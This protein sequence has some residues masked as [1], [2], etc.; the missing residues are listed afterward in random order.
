MDTSSIARSQRREPSGRCQTDPVQDDRHRADTRSAY[1][2]L[3]PVW[4]ETDDNLFNEYLERATVRALLPLMAPGSRVLYA[5]CAGGAHA[6]WLAERGCAVVGFDLSPSMMARTGTRCGDQAHF[7]V[8]DLVA[9]PFLGASFDGILCSLAL[10][11]VADMSTT[12]GEF[13]R[14][15]R[16]DGWL[17]VTLDHPFGT[18]AGDSYFTTRLATEDWAKKGVTV[19][20]SFWRRPLG[21][22]IDAFADAGFGVERIG[23]PQ[24]DDAMRARFPEDAAKVEGRPTFIAYLARRSGAA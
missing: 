16:P 6:A 14:I 1:E 20:Q 21:E 2:R 18:P 23:E 9:P 19:T 11:Y 8:A 12:L 5:G 3:A 24:L 10:H 7:L 22:T 15:L 13:A 17:L 4:D